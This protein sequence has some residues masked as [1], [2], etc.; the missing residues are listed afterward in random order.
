MIILTLG[1]TAVLLLLI[2][3]AIVA[4]QLA[5]AIAEKSFNKVSSPPPYQSRD[6]V[7]ALHSRLFIADLHA[8]SLLWKRDLLKRRDYGHVDLPRLIES[9]VAL[10]VFGVVTKAPKGQNFERN[11]ADSDQ[12]TTLVVAQ[13][14]PP[15]TWG[16]LLQRAL[17]QAQKLERFEARS[18]GRLMRIKSV[19][20][21]D[22]FLARRE[23]DPK[24]VAAFPA[25]EGVHALEGDLANLDLLFDAGFCMIGLAH[26]FDNE[27]GGSAHGMEQG[28]LTPFGR[29][30]VQAIQK[31]NMLLDLA[32]SS[33]LVIDDVLE[34]TTA[35]VIVSH[36][37]VRG[38]CDNQR[39]LSDEHVRRIAATGGIMGIA[40][41]K[42]AVC[43]TAIDDTARAMRYVADLVG[44]EHVAVG[45]DFDGA[46]ETAIDVTGMVLLTDA[47]VNQGFG[48]AEISQIMGKNVLRVFREVLPET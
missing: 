43:G 28:G 11:A 36:T 31:K 23:R 1:C 10:Q 2:L 9:N 13:A 33:P 48:E 26:F 27:A 21:L 12:V 8:D 14:W 34:M 20:D 25:L 40:L 47:L 24:I 5:P 22:E 44:V 3:A 46:T 30:L 17:Y 29:E 38:D 41:F 18:Q 6:K 45:S 37:G 42:Q 32:H 19:H 35:P 39:N 15:R 16:S 4:L 7:Q